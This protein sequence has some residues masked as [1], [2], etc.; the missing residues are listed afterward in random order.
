MSLASELKI[1]MKKRLKSSYIV[2]SLLTRINKGSKTKI[3][4]FKV[5]FLLKSF[6]SSQ[7][8]HKYLIHKHSVKELSDYLQT[9]RNWSLDLSMHLKPMP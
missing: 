9:L 5:P 6:G 3:C 2:N 4:T 8:K 7:S 1:F